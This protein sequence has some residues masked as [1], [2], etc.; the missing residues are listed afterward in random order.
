MFD[1]FD[2]IIESIKSVFKEIWRVISRVWREIRRIL[3]QLWELVEGIFSAVASALAWVVV[4][5]VVVILLMYFPPF[6]AFIT[7][8]IS[9]LLVTYG[10]AA[11]GTVISTYMAIAYLAGAALVLG[12]IG[13]LLDEEAFTESLTEAAEKVGEAVGAIIG[14]VGKAVGSAAGAVA[15]GIGLGRILLWGGLGFLTYKVLTDE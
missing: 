12:S 11:A 14:A 10:Y 6:A 5:I 13:Y 8:G 1:F 9:T 4:L 2:D 7:E 15:K 3:D